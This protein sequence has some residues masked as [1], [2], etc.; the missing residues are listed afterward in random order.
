MWVPEDGANEPAP[1]TFGDEAA[2]GAASS[3]WFKRRSVT[4]ALW[5]VL[6]RASNAVGGTSSQHARLATVFLGQAP[7]DNA[8]RIFETEVKGASEASWW[9]RRQLVAALEALSP[10]ESGYVTIDALISNSSLREAQTWVH[11]AIE[12]VAYDGHLPPLPQRLSSGWLQVRRFYR[13]RV[14]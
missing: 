6:A 3:G 7:S 4:D 11:L 1:F 5:M 12:C 13:V 14:S 2:V 8:T 9:K 10:E